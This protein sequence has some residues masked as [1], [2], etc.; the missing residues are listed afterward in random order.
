[1]SKSKRPGGKN[2]IRH[3][4]QESAP[5]SKPTPTQPEE[6]GVEIIK[7]R[8]L[9][10]EKNQGFTVIKVVVGAVILLIL[11]TAVATKIAG[12][13]G[14][15]RGDKLQGEKCTATVECAPGHICYAYEGDRERC[16]ATCSPERPC[17]PEF[18]CKSN[19]DRKVR[20][21]VTMHNVCV[22]NSKL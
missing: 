9:S 17:Q 15:G 22:A 16:M 21:G 18:T 20:K 8:A 2:V 12:Q 13:Q 4:A 14:T 10:R 5:K 11:G 19:L 6:E 3:S 1:M 7:A